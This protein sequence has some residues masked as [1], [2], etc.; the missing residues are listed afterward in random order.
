M[1]CLSNCTKGRPV[2]S[3]N[4]TPRWWP[5][6]AVAI[7]LVSLSVTIAG[8]ALFL[9][10]ST[11]T[12][13][14]TDDS[15]VELLEI[16]VEPG[17]EVAIEYTHSV[18]QTPVTDVYTVS[19][20]ALVDDRMLFSSFGAGLPSEADVTRE[21]DRYVHRPPAQRHDPLIITTG[22]LADHSLLVDGER[23]DLAGLA[24]GG[25]VELRIEHQRTL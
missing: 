5:R 12:L 9:T 17:S 6:F 19:D 20:G 15:G 2:T 22:P 16:D 18:E 21:G 1:G 13:V 25:T 11:T 10:T 24:D 14:V 8:G 23:Y 3:S 4:V 7:L